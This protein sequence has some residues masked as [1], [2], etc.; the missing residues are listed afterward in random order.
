MIIFDL[1]CANGHTFEGWFEDADAFETQS[2]N[3]L[4]TCP[5]C[6]DTQISKIF[7]S[8]AIK[9]SPG[10]QDAPVE[11]AE[12]RQMVKK[13]SEFVEKHFDNV[14]CQFAT[15]AL[16][17]HYGVSEP[18]NIRGVSTEQEEKMLKD[19][20]VEFFKVPSLTPEKTDT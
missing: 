15:E 5:V 4:V 3:K 8:I 6:E 19:E 12:M 14:G 7:S 20:G 1:K 9:S 11:P 13:I 18:R 2:R 17:M 16:K 10:V